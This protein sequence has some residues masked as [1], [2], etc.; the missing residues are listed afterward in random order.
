MAFA[1]SLSMQ[2]SLILP[3]LLPAS[4]PQPHNFCL[5]VE[6]YDIQGREE[7]TTRKKKTSSPGSQVIVP[8]SGSLGDRLK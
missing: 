6:I 4:Q 8:C 7:K 2:V 1:V 3:N 5:L